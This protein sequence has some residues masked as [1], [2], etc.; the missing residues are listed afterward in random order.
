MANMNITER[1]FA[2]DGHMSNSGLSTQRDVR[3]GSG[4]TIY[5]ERIVLR[6]MPDHSTYTHLEELGL[7]EEQL[8]LVKQHAGRPSGMVMSVGPVGSGKSTTIAGKRLS[9]SASRRLRGKTLAG[10]IRNSRWRTEPKP[11]SIGKSS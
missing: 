4:P 6:L 2:Q 8:Q 11:P 5:G 7:E 9:Q 1:R 10:H 3:V